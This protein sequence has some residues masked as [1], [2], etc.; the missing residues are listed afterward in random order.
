MESNSDIFKSFE[1]IVTS[2]GYPVESHDIMTQDGYILKVFRIPHGKMDSVAKI[3]ANDEKIPRPVAF[4]QHG[5]LDSSDAFISHHEDKALAFKLANQGYDV[6]LGNTRGNKY[7][8][9][10]NLLHADYEEEFWDFSFHEMGLYDLPASFD[11]IKNKTGV[12]KINYVGHSQGTTQMFAAISLKPEYFKKTINTFMALGPATSLSNLGSDPVKFMLN[13]N[14]PNFFTGILHEFIP[15]PQYTGKIASYLCHHLM[16]VCDKIFTI[17]GDIHPSEEDRER[18]LVYLSRLPSSTSLK[19]L[20]HFDMVFKSKFSHFDYGEHN[21]KIY[22]QSTPLEYN[23]ENIKDMKIGLI[24]GKQDKLSTV[25]DTRLLRDF[26]EVN[27]A[28][29][30][31]KEYD[32][33]GHHSFFY[34][35]EMSWTDDVSNFLNTHN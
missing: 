29:G 30:F 31:Y 24:V 4:L 8:R 18:F 34:G 22:G 20:R 12:E 3:N 35:S 28:L 1:E 32:K 14:L 33:M 27:N 21:H 15:V 23:L 11:Y 17:F 13:N 7:S 2:K 16:P 5:V 10:H 9:N 26:L 19:S 6:W 25:E